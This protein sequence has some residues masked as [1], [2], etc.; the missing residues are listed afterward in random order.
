MVNVAHNGHDRR[1]GLEVLLGIVEVFGNQRG[2]RRLLLLPLEGNLE[3][4]AHQLGGIEVD[5]AVD[6]GHVAQHE[7][8]L[9]D[10]AG[11]LADLFGQVA[12][13]DGVAGHVRR[14]NL[15]GRHH[16]LGAGLLRPG[17]LAA[18]D[19]LIVIAVE[20][21][22]AR[23]LPVPAHM[24]RIVLADIVF[25]VRVIVGY[26]FLFHRN[27]QFGCPGTAR[28]GAAAVLAESAALLRTCTALGAACRTAI[29]ALL[30]RRTSI[31]QQF[32]RFPD[33]S[34]GSRDE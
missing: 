15:D 18:A 22:L 19:H 10:F 34:G 27:R 21:V 9:D 11:G 31:P 12:H 25:L 2:F 33:L 16:L 3:V 32:F 4:G 14:L 7:Q 5:F 24:L 8:L 28:T 26:P 20:G 13:G 30:S 29:L 1:T 17:A 6:G 23:L